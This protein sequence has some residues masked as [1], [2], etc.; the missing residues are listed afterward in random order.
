M[1]SHAEPLSDDFQRQGLCWVLQVEALPECLSWVQD[2]KVDGSG[3][4]PVYRS[5][6][7]CAVAIATQVC[8]MII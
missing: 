8:V 7:V 2:G 6:I 5:Q 4:G 3:G 1:A